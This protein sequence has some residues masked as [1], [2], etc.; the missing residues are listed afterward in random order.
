[1]RD[2]RYLFFEQYLDPVPNL[3]SRISFMPSILYMYI[4]IYTYEIAAGTLKGAG[5]RGLGKDL[6]WR[7]R[8]C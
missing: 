6:E 8:S 3:F 5:C 1:M 4:Y 7:V 2:L